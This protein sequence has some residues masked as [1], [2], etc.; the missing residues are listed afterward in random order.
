MTD[1]YSVEHI[2]L[3]NGE[4]GVEFEIRDTENQED[5]VT[6]TRTDRKGEDFIILTYG[7]ARGVSQAINEYLEQKEK[8]KVVF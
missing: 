3:V 4:P 2:Y 7:E 5:C 8:D 1:K 6:L